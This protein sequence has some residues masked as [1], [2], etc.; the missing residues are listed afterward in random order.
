MRSFASFGAYLGQLQSC[1]HRPRC[2]VPLGRY[3]G[4]DR[5]GHKRSTLA[6][7]LP[8]QD[9]ARCFASSRLQ[10]LGCFPVLVVALRCWPA[11]WVAWWYLSVGRST[12]RCWCTVTAIRL[13][14][15]VI[16]VMLV[17]VPAT[18]PWLFALVVDTLLRWRPQNST[19][20]SN[21]P[22]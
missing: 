4:R 17:E 20:G 16:L 19:S 8:L 12:R 7:K 11:S 10:R 1:Q 9:M 2:F 18:S 5:I 14:S 6:G 13:Y 3:T 15:Q 22:A 21:G